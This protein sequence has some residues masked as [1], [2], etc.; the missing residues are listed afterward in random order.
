MTNRTPELAEPV[1][2]LLSDLVRKRTGFVVSDSHRSRMETRLSGEALAAGSFYQLYTQLREEPTDSPAFGRLIDASVN[3]ETYF[4]RDPDGLAAFSEEIVP[5]RIL[6]NG[7]ESEV[8]IWS[9]G[10]ATGE[11]PYTLAMILAERGILPGRKVR[12]RGTDASPDA[13]R[14]ARLATYGSHALRSTSEI[15]RRTLFE[16]AG[17]GRWIVKS[18]LRQ[19]V[20]FECLPFN[21]E[22]R[23]GTLMDVIICRNVL[24]Y[25]DEEA[26]FQALELFSERLKPGGYLLLGPSDALAASATPLKLVRLSHDVA[27]RK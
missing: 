7:Q 24:I 2:R 19:L 10:C 6:A 1:F 8:A 18:E 27:Y 4:F 23:S 21:L 11:E 25:L 5:E 9:A 26:R 15:R 13:I 22:S 14:R 3:G 20:V 12:I 16:E 17:T